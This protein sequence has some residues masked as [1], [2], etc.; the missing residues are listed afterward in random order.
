M[1]AQDPSGMFDI[2]LLFLNSSVACLINWQYSVDKVS[3]SG[4]TQTQTVDACVAMGGVCLCSFVIFVT[5][6]G[7]I[8][9]CVFMV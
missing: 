6:L 1:S 2:F 5:C 7:Y 9:E 4:N 8:F 3:A